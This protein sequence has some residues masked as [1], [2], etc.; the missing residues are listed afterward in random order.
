VAIGLVYHEPSGGF[1]YHLWTEAWLGDR[2]VPFD[3]TLARG[4][5][6]G[7]HLKITDSN[8][9][10][11]SATSAFLPVLQVLGQMEIESAEIQ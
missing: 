11:A 5:I 2:W 6:G 7:A 3:A 1:A 10:G 8:L 9:A 4:G